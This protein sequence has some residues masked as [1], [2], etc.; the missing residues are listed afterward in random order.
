[1]RTSAKKKVLQEALALTEKQRAEVAHEL[2]ASLDGKPDSG[3]EEAWEETIARR[4]AEVREGKAK[5][6]PWSEVLADARK[7]IAR[8]RRR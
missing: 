6:F 4:V 8:P 7:I 5:T 1:M 2:I 3:V